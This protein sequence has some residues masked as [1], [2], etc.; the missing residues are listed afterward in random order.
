MH[1]D[2][3]LLARGVGA[4]DLLLFM[5]QGDTIQFRIRTVHLSE[6]TQR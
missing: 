4:V 3:W 6:Y 5:D 1:E 2:G